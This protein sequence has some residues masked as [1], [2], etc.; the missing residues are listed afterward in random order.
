MNTVYLESG[1]NHWNQDLNSP[2]PYP[3]TDA[4]YIHQEDVTEDGLPPIPRAT[5]S[6]QGLEIIMI[7]KDARNLPD[8]CL[9]EPLSSPDRARH[10]GL[11]ATQSIKAKSKLVRTQSN[12][13]K[14][15]SSDSL[16]TLDVSATGELQTLF[17]N[18][19]TLFALEVSG[20]GQSWITDPKRGN[21]RFGCLWME[22][23]NIQIP[24]RLVSLS[25]RACNDEGEY[26]PFLTMKLHDSGLY[27]GQD[28]LGVGQIPIKQLLDLN[29]KGS[30][31]IEC[32]LEDAVSG[33]PLRSANGQ[34]TVVQLSFRRMHMD[35]WEM[36]SLDDTL[37]ACDHDKI[38]LRPARMKHIANFLSPSLS[39]A[40]V[41]F[42]VCMLV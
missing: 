30:K 13:S 12:L 3:Y 1:Y 8:V 34:Q 32:L 29:S 11:P 14:S 27:S 40:E 6:Q 36:P 39:V 16:N 20:G 35:A 9:A 22:H 31:N 21:S 15:I 37:R 18:R 2:K 10:N 26:G 17:N 23:F 7:V 19:S 25:Q 24:E 33:E 41:N 38:V 28:V 5:G 4:I 42:R